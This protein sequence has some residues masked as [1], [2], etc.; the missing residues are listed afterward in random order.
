MDI[1]GMLNTTCTVSTLT[2]TQDAMSGVTETYAVRLS[3]VPCRTRLL[4]GNEIPAL[5]TDRSNST[6]RVYMQ[7]SADTNTITDKDRIT[8]AG[9]RVFDVV[10]PNDVDEQEDLLQIDCKERKNG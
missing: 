5:G 2:V 9:G 6:H 7:P 8:T 4:K 3:G 1:S 10:F